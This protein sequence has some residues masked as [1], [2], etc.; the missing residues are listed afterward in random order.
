MPSQTALER[1]VANLEKMIEVSR[2]LRSAFDLDSLLQEIIRAI[3]ELAE[4][5]KSSILLLDRDSGELHFVAVSGTEFDDVKDIAVPRQGSIAGAIVET[6]K[7]VVVN[8]AQGDPR[9]FAQVDRDTGNVTRSL[10]GVP[11]EIG[12]RVI[13]VLEAVNKRDDGEFDQ[14]D[15]ETL[16]MF[17]AQAAAAIETTRLI[18]E[19]RQRLSEVLLLQD[20]LMT[21]SRHIQMDSLLQQ[22]LM[23]LEDSLGYANCAV[24]IHD[25]ERHTLRVIAHRGFKGTVVANRLYPVDGRTI[26]GRVA[27]S[28]TPLIA[29]PEQEEHVA[30]LLPDTR[31]IL[32]VPMQCGQSEDLVG[33]ISVE[34]A[35]ENAFH[36]HDV[37]M[38]ST[39]ATQAAIGIRQAEL[40][41]NSRRANRL[42]Q[43][44]ITTMSHELRTPLTVI[45][46][47]CDM[48]A[49]ETLGP[50]NEGQISA[51]KVIHDRAD[52][53]L[54]LLNDVLDL[55]K[56]V[57]GEL[58]L[59]PAIVS[60]NKA[61]DRV[62]TKYRPYAERKKQTITVEIPPECQYVMADDQRLRQVLGH[63]IDNA[64]K[65]SPDGRP[66]VI[67]VS[68]HDE[69]YV[70]VD[71]ID[72]GI[73]IKKEDIEH[74]FEDFRQL[75]SSFTR[76]YG[77]AGLGLSI[78]KHLIELQGGVIWVESEFG[79]GSTFSF[80]LHR[81]AIREGQTTPEP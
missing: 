55:S 22:L 4:C 40:Y 16:L 18:E 57:S 52:L 12:G 26:Y 64:I 45:I 53:L 5:E 1:R 39:V 72:R 9:H 27:L 76:D 24:W 51:L 31:S 46:G 81:P 66:I 56:I 7:P 29:S 43:E 70:R 63:L 34:R 36:E 69:D 73:G 41:E 25:P 30:P 50:L 65:F 35:M 23:L 42:K 3:V 60:L 2:A 15:V 33:V 54:R 32:A 62:L 77:G 68:P 75:D 47:Y 58:E 21:L 17:A 49:R 6:R 28:R 74:L 44:F 80:I 48:L 10:I 78:S 13:G 59:R 8:Q 14:E 71:V 61:I 20:V 79:K 38:L 67:R 11:L 19:Q 37:R